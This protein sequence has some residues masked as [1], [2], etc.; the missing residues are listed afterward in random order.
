MNA[1][2]IE[3][4][5]KV[6]RLLR[7]LGRRPDGYHEVVTVL[8]AVD[9]WDALE[10]RLAPGPLT[11]EV[12]E[13]D[14]A[15][16]QEEN[17][18]WRAA[19][20]YLAAAGRPAEGVRIV[21]T[22][23]IPSGAGLG[24]GSSD[25]A[26]ALRAMGLLLGEPVGARQVFEIASRL[27]ADVP[28]FLGGSPALGTG[29]GDRL[30]PLESFGALWYVLAK[31]GFAVSTA[32]AYRGLGLT[33]LPSLHSMRR[34]DSADGAEIEKLGNDLERSVLPVHPEIAAL[35]AHLMESGALGAA[36]SGSGSAVFGLFAERGAAEAAERELLRST[37]CWVRVA[38][39]VDGRPL[40]RWRGGDH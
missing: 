26:A 31:P 22:K 10:A 35:K 36:M 14:F 4:P 7:V 9:L 37:S 17:L 8:Q 30:Q 25:A 34:F 16:P 40:Q 3:T 39:P 27:G 23:A 29:V 2:R 18:V 19:A 12:R 13:A 28:F 20:A 33:A 5:A 24:G 6:N 38:R 11:V 15:I 21:L 32:E 1:L